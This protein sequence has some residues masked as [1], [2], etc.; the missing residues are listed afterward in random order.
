MFEDLKPCP[1]CGGK[2]AL[3]VNGGVRVICQKCNARTREVC[4]M[5]TGRGMAGNAT[6]KVIKLWNARVGEEKEGTADA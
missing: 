2:A 3:Y 1:F 4:D 6:A 5:L